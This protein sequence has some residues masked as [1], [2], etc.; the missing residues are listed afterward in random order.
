MQGSRLS[1]ELAQWSWSSHLLLSLVIVDF[2]RQALGLRKK[3]IIEPVVKMLLYSVK[4]CEDSESVAYLKYNKLACHDFV[5]AVKKTTWY[6]WIRDQG[7]Y[8]YDLASS[9]SISTFASVLL[10]PRLH[11][12]S[13]DGHRRKPVHHWLHFRTGV[14]SLGTLGIVQY[15]KGQFPPED[16]TLLLVNTVSSWTTVLYILLVCL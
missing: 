10:A 5:G 3:K 8:Y 2:T 14:L 16:G 15:S 4:N 9:K 1:L 6:S 13:T 12:S 11:R 7:L